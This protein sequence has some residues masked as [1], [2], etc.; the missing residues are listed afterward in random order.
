HESHHVVF[1]D[2]FKGIDVS[3][4]GEGRHKWFSGLLQWGAMPSPRSA[5][6]TSDSILRLDWTAAMKPVDTTTIT[7][8][9]K[10]F[11]YAH[12]WRFGYFEARMRWNPVA[13]AWPAFWLFDPQAGHADRHS[14]EIDVFEGQAATPHTYY[15]SV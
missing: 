1:S 6:H 5:I 15:G 14:C 2:D 10:D 3:P 12:T 8:A 4:N 7:T 9:A 13:G 11:S